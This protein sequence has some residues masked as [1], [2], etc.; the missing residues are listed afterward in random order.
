MTFTLHGQS[1]TLTLPL[2]TRGT[3][4]LTADG[5]IT[6]KQTDFGITPY[7]VL[8]GAIAVL[9]EISLRYHLVAGSA[10]TPA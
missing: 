10:R 1:R 5:S 7:A 6:L 2:Q 4:P 8:G 9:D 3:D